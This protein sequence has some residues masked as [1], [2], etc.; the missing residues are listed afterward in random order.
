MQD[1]ECKIDRIVN[2]NGATHVAIEM[3]AQEAISLAF[4]LRK[5]REFTGKKQ[6]IRATVK[7]AIREGSE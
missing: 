7:G 6:S 1:L 2:I 5:G 4:L 3:D